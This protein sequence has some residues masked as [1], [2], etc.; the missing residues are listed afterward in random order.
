M[1]KKVTK[2]K[3]TKKESTKLTEKKVEEVKEVK[4]ATVEGRDAVILVNIFAPTNEPQEY[5][6]RIPKIVN[7]ASVPHRSPSYIAGLIVGALRKKYGD[8]V[9]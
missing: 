1:K 3:T 7:N 6:I 9:S 2:K 5:K 4:K 8:K